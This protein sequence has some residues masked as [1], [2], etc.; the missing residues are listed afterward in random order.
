MRALLIDDH[1]M[2]IQALKTLL[3]LMAPE[4]ELDTAS[5]IQDGVTLVAANPYEL[6]LL[7][8]H[9]AD[10]EGAEAIHRLR[11]AG[12]LAR[13]VVLSGVTENALIRQS[14][15]EGAAG[16][17]PKRYSSELMLAALKIVVNGGIYLPPEALRDERG[18][19]EVPSKNDPSPLVDIA[20]RYGDL[21]PR[22]ADVYRAAARGLSNKLIARE[23]GI[24]ESTVKTHL[25]T[26]F[27]ILGVSNRTQAAY[28]AS[29]EGF[30]IV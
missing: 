16:F 24:A 8:W 10:C 3:G 1:V 27:A 20:S 29:R 18:R 14:V 21:T 12:S 2:F 11:G 28:Q 6:V 30:R 17:I 23:L 22:Q 9:L 26:V 5:S 19:R 13:I 15:D 7:D 4:L 25:S